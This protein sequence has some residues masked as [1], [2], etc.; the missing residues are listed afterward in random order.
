MYVQ[1]ASSGLGEKYIKNI[2]RKGKGFL[3][4]LDQL[5]SR[6]PSPESDLRQKSSENYHLIFLRAN[7]HELLELL[8][9]S[10]HL[11]MEESVMA[12]DFVFSAYRDTT[13]CSL[14]SLALSVPSQ[15]GYYKVSEEDVYVQCCRNLAGISRDSPEYSW[16]VSH[17]QLYGMDPEIRIGPG[18]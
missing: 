7:L 10:T 13:K 15:A 3:V 5:S 11:L 9:D 14:L 12:L 1:P 18:L 4:I 16:D 8:K 17:N 6:W 2:K